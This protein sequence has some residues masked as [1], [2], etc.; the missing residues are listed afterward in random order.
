[1]ILKRRLVTSF[2]FVTCCSYNYSHEAQKNIS[3]CT[4]KV[5]KERPQLFVQAEKC[6]QNFI[7]A[8]T[9][10]LQTHD[11]RTRQAFKQARGELVYF[12][13]MLM[14]HYDDLEEKKTGACTVCEKA[15]TVNIKNRFLELLKSSQ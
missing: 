5:A 13:G 3:E 4:G 2:L 9:E 7:N 14:D 1:M 15:E 8:R 12:V 11:C 6:E 10:C